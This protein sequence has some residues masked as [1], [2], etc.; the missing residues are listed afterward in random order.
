MQ[1]LDQPLST[2]RDAVGP[3]LAQALHSEPEGWA[4]SVA[5]TRAWLGAD[6]SRHI[7]TLDDARFPRSL[8][9]TA[10]PPLLMYAQGRLEWLDAP[11]IAIVGS[12]HPT[13]QGREHAR[14]FA[15]ALGNSGYTIVSGLA[16]GIDGAAHEGALETP[17]ATIAVVGTGIDRIYPAR[18]EKLARRIAVQ[19]LLLSEL[20]LGSAPLPENFPQRNRI[21]AGLARGTLV[22]EAAVQSGSLITARLA[23]ECGRD[24]FAIPGSIHSPQS[25]GCHA[26]IKQGAKLVEDAQDVLDELRGA[27]ARMMPIGTTRTPDNDNDIT[28]AGAS[29]TR[30]DNTG[31]TLAPRD[32]AIIDA[33]GF[34]PVSLDTVLDRTG[35]DT[36]TAQARLLDLELEGHVQRLPGGRFQRRSRS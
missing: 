28:E 1:V 30:V 31:P 7:I 3:T 17:C 15:R 14:A 22:V 11:S 19:G 13:P 34:D 12:R 35:L 29:Q 4:A 23:N 18:H 32:A 24:V 2:L 10:D 33:M 16:I 9:D 21:I 6:A 8:L 5:A 26:L 20:P 25:R 27:G 36:A